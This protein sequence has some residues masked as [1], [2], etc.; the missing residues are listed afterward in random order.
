MTT[1][2]PHNVA[3]FLREHAQAR[4]DAPA[5]TVPADGYTTDA[6]VWSTT[7]YGELD[8]ASDRVAEGL[9]QQGVIPGDRTLVLVQPGPELYIAVFALFKIGAVPVI[10]DPGMGLKGL[11]SCIQRTRPRVMIADSRVHLLSR[12]R[13]SPFASVRIRVTLGRRWLWGGVTWGQLQATPTDTPRA[14]LDLDPDAPA[15]LLF[16]SGSTGPAKGVIA[17]H[18]ML[19]A[20]VELLREMLGVQAGWTDLQAFAGFALFD[21]CLG[22]HAALPKMNLSR[23]ATA[24]PEELLAAYRTL[25]PEVAFGSPVVW[26]NLA[27]HALASGSTLPSLRVALT[28]GAP[29]PAYLHQRLL[30]VFAPERQIFTPYGATEALPIAWIGTDEILSETWA[31][32]SQGAGT[33]VGA[34]VPHTQVRIIDVTDAPLASFDE[35]R[36]LAVGE[37]GEIVVEGPQVSRAYADAEEANL[38]AKIQDGTRTWHRMGDLGYLDAQGR[39]WFCGRK[40]HRLQTPAGIVP[41][42][43]VE[44][45]FNEH[46]DVF[47]TALV[48]VGSV[49][50][51]RPVLCVELEPDRAWST[52][53]PRELAALAEGTPYAGLVQ[54]FLHHPGFPTDARHNSKIR[55]EDLA[56][57]ATRQCG[58]E[59]PSS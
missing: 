30:Q 20:Q 40:A 58:H 23:P 11:L 41:A 52:S 36:Q 34:P 28:V 44:G 4:P 49:G 26:Q 24:R 1:G 54:Q 12:L 59:E 53:L 45:I 7:R 55:R 6:P 50:A 37:L 43:P 47:R 39:L 22:M 56:P 5:L 15:A 33:C 16:T 13:P 38:H 18:G 17:R 29:I 10:L 32:T 35:T 51:H 14:L 27:R 3:R 42:V 46:P 19:G 2:A 25:E 9:A 57:W 31:A 8:E 21:L 48:G